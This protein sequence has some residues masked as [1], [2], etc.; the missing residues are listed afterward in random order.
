MKEDPVTAEASLLSRGVF[1]RSLI[2]P[3]PH[4]ST[5]LRFGIIKTESFVESWFPSR[6]LVPSAAAP[7]WDCPQQRLVLRQT[8]GPLRSADPA[9]DPEEFARCKSLHPPVHDLSLPD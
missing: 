9:A 1:V 5:G 3:L 4:G 7:R 2:T 8:L 6:P